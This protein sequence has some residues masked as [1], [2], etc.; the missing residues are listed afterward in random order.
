MVGFAE[1]GSITKTPIGFKD[2][3]SPFLTSM[4]ASRLEKG[5]GISSVKK[6]DEVPSI[7]GSETSNSHMHGEGKCQCKRHNKLH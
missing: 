4:G 1:Q 6:V 7:S 5:Q 2:T 3:M